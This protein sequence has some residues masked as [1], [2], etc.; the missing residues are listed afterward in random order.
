MVNCDTIIE[1]IKEF[2]PDVIGMSG[3]I[4]PSLDEMISNIR[5]FKNHSI[6]SPILIGGATTSRHIQL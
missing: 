5:E 2:E 3:L 6:T 4:T 1:N